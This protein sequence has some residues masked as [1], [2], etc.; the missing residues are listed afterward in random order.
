MIIYDKYTYIRTYIY[1]DEQILTSQVDL[2]P[3]FLA[4]LALATL[5]VTVDI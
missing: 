5:G 4:S 1:I 3:R 2:E